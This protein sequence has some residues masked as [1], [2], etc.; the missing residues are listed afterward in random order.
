MAGKL[1]N[2][3]RL[4]EING[5]ANKASAAKLIGLGQFYGI[6]KRMASGYASHI[7]TWAQKEHEMVE[8]YLRFIGE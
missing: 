5:L 2:M 3:L 8:K 4:M 7:N 1:L 6:S